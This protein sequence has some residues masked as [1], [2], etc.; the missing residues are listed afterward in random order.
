M[1][2]QQNLHTVCIVCIFYLFGL[3]SS[4]LPW[5]IGSGL[6]VLR[7]FEFQLLKSQVLFEWRTLALQRILESF[8]QTEKKKINLNPLSKTLLPE[9]QVTFENELTFL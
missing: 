1:F 3:P 9:S 8:Q 4:L 2:L 7:L 5:I 6:C